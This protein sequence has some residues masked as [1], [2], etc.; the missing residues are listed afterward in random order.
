MLELLDAAAEGGA[1]AEAAAARRQCEVQSR[2]IAM[3][4]LLLPLPSGAE[5]A[6]AALG[7]DPLGA[8]QQAF[9]EARSALV[10]YRHGTEPTL[11]SRLWGVWY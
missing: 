4:G 8:A 11:G 1:A 9:T 3:R 6:A 5:A 10:P 2:L 7:A